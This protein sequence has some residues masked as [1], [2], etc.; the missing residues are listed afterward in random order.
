M[1]DKYKAVNC[2]IYFNKYKNAMV[3]IPIK[4]QIFPIEKHINTN[5]QQA[6][7]EYEGE[8]VILN[9]INLYIMAQINYA[10]RESKASEEGARMTAMDSATKNANELINKL[11]LKLNRSRQDIITK[12]L[13]EIIAGAEAI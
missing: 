9:M 3:Q 13:T 5:S 12:D 1:L 7:Y 10:L 4:K 11:T 2:Q 6:S 8:D